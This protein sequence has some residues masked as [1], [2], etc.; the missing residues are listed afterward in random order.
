M[1]DLAYS[2]AQVHHRLGVPKPT[3]RNWSAEYAQFLSD[4]ARPDEGKTRLFTYDDLIVLNTVRYYARIEGVNNNDRIRQVLASGLRITELPKRR[5]REEERALD[6]VQ[7]VPASQLEQAIAQAAS[8]KREAEKKMLE[9]TENAR[10][11]D[12]ARIAL[13]SANNTITNLTI[14]RQQSNGILVGLGLT[15]IGLGMLLI[16]MMLRVWAIP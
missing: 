1:T 13:Q 7:L 8:L 6:Q 9:A 3:I 12:R 10:E 5:T 16:I 14:N 4:R 2:T 11:R 15:G